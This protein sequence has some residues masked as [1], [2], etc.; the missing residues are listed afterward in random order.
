MLAALASFSQGSLIPSLSDLPTGSSVT[1]T[2]V[3]V[4]PPSDGLHFLDNATPSS[5]RDVINGQWLGGAATSVYKYGYVS[6]DAIFAAPIGQSGFYA[7]AVRLYVGQLLYDQ[8]LILRTMAQND[9]VLKSL[10][11]YITVGGWYTHD[12]NNNIDRA[13]YYMGLMLKFGS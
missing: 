12:I 3:V 9:I 7:P 11:N 8:V 13:G 2:S 1:R 4:S 6:L 10:L 5:F